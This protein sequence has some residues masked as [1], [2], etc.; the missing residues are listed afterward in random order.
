MNIE[1]INLGIELHGLDETK[2]RMVDIINSLQDSE[3]KLMLKIAELN[4]ALISI[5]TAVAMIGDDKT[6][7]ILNVIMKQV[8][9]KFDIEDLTD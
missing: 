6:K 2:K 3:K 8:N 9:G 1:T 7:A 4:A 5:N